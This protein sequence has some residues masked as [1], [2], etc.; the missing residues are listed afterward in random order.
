M[1]FSDMQVGDVFTAGPYEITETEI[2]D[3]ARRYDPQPFHIDKTSSEASFWG[4]LIASGWMTCSLAMKLCATHILAGSG[5][6]GGPG[7][8]DL[9]WESPVRPGDRLRL[10]VTVLTRR[11]SSS[12]RYGVIRWRWEMHKQSDQR[13]LCL[14]VT[15][16][17]NSKEEAK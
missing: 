3:F 4:G 9:R 8:E 12:G 15:S 13:A 14:V 2:L 17:F 1:R 16:L 11:M 6:I 5:S 7:V 10:T